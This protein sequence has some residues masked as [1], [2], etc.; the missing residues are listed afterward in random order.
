MISSTIHVYN[1]SETNAFSNIFF[2]ISRTFLRFHTNK[3]NM[4]INK[5]GK[6]RGYSL[7]SYFK[8]NFSLTKLIKNMAVTRNIYIDE[9]LFDKE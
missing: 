1:Q 9:I 3:G 6:F 2:I 4:F 5:Y 7:P 8:R